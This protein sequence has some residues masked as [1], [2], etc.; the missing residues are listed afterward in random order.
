[1]VAMLAG[2][3]MWTCVALN[4]ASAVGTTQGANAL[5]YLSNTFDSSVIIRTGAVV[6]ALEWLI[7]AFT[8]IIAL[9]VSAV[10]HAAYQV[11]IFI[12]GSGGAAAAVA[13]QQPMMAVNPMM[14]E[15]MMQAMP[16]MDPRYAGG[17]GG[18]YGGGLFGGFNPFNRFRNW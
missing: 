10:C 17:Y 4:L 16:V 13:M 6:I 11:P 15:P 1:M 12:D 14:V 9:G 18:G 7:V 3:S 2:G 5:Q 8:F